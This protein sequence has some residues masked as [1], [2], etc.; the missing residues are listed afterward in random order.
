MACL[1]PGL[2]RPSMAKELYAAHGYSSTTKGKVESYCNVAQ[3]LYDQGCGFSAR[4]PL[5]LARRNVYAITV[6][7]KFSIRDKIV[8]LCKIAQVRSLLT[9]DSPIEL[10][11]ARHL[12]D[13]VPFAEKRACEFAW[14]QVYYELGKACVAAGE[15]YA[16]SYL[17]T[18]REYLRNG[19]HVD[20]HGKLV[21]IGE[22]EILVVDALCKIAVEE[23][24]IA[25]GH[26]A[27]TLKIALEKA[28]YMCFVA[29]YLQAERLVTISDL[30]FSFDPE[31]AKEVLTHANEIMRKAWDPRRQELIACAKA[32]L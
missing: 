20:E 11:E 31:K 4:F 2:L 10:E 5:S 26:S 18:A 12:D 1:V 23:Q 27:L 9:V 29:P 21:H 28:E 24:K 3:H 16:Q 14:S 13:I 7:D 22:G 30:Y 6:N 8:S 19:Y 15:N 25:R 17:T 32:K